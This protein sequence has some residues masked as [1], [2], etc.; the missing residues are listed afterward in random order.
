MSSA[1]FVL[2][3]DEELERSKPIKQP[4]LAVEKGGN[5]GQAGPKPAGGAAV[6]LA[7]ADE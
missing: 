5:P 6:V 3:E 7:A 2:H 4:V 1:A